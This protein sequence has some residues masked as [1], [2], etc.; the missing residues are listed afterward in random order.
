MEHGGQHLGG[1]HPVFPI[2]APAGDHTGQVVVIHEE[3]VPAGVVE[4]V[5]PVSHALFEGGQ[6]QG[7]HVP[8]VLAGLVV[9]ADVLELEH[10][11]QLAAVGGGVELGTFHVSAPG[12]A[13]GHQTLFAEGLPGQ[14]PEVFVQAGAVA[15]DLQ[16]GLLG[17]LVDDVQTEAFDAL[18]DPEADHVI[19]FPADIGIFPIQV[20]LFHRKLME[21]ILAK[22]GHP[23]PAGAAEAGPHAVGRGDAVAITPDE[24]IVVGVVPALQR[25]LEPE[26]LIGAVV[27]DQVENDG[28]AP[29]F[30]FC[31][32]L[33]HILH[34]AEH[35]IDGPVVGDVIAV[36]HLGGGTDGRHPDAV[37]AQ[38]FQIIQPGNDAPQV[39]DAVAVGV[40]E[41][42]GVDLVE[43]SGFPPAPLAF[44]KHDSCHNKFLYCA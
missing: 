31:D 35:G 20:G 30:R 14:F 32:E 38:I 18:I 13:H 12:F 28:N 15:G 37:D 10:H 21:V 39:T 8:L 26:M 23:G 5:L 40:L 4:A 27:Q 9:Q 33:F 42:L 6:V 22:M 2:V 19:Q 3:A 41:A 11:A 44:I 17:D 25:F 16:V 1:F 24:V 34:G 43:N 29:F 36:V 7:D